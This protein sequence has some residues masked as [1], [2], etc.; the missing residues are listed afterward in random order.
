MNQE[1]DIF[2]CDAFKTT[3]HNWKRIEYPA[4]PASTT[5]FLDWL[6]Q[7][8][9]SLPVDVSLVGFVGGRPFN[10]VLQSDD[11][12]D[13][14][15]NLSLSGIPIDLETRLRVELENIPVLQSFLD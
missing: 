1:R 15:D 12:P 11:W 14:S 7:E 13:L 6:K 3:A 8:W 4:R 5:G 2:M 10:V 9:L